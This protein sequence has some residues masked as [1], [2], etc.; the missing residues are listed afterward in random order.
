MLYVLLICRAQVV[1]LMAQQQGQGLIWGDL[2]GEVNLRSSLTNR[3]ETQLRL[4]AGYL[5]RTWW[6]TGLGL[7]LHYQP[8]EML[9][10]GEIYRSWS[11][12]AAWWNRVYVSAK[13]SGRWFISGQF[14]P[15]YVRPVFIRSQGRTGISN[16]VIYAGGGVGHT[17]RLGEQLWLDMNL[18]YR[19]PIYDQKNRETPGELNLRVGVS[20]ILVPKNRRS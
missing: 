16:W 6:A 8:D 5:P 4:G 3:P 10:G 14:S 7:N 18:Y 12:G 17:F 11:I 15:Q 9:P 19:H 1:P 2:T 20:G 13:P